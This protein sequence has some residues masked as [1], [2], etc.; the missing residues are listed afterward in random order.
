MKLILWII[1]KKEINNRAQSKLTLIFQFSMNENVTSNF[2]LLQVERGNNK[3]KLLDSIDSLPEGTNINFNTSCFVHNMQ[4]ELIKAIYIY[5]TWEWPLTT[6]G[7]KLHWAENNM[8]VLI[9]TNYYTVKVKKT[10]RTVPPRSKT[11]VL[12]LTVEMSSFTLFPSVSFQYRQDTFHA[13]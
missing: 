1:V 5:P 13:C 8:I 2:S 7:H 4:I 3:N 10:S 11:L 12:I 9:K 6:L